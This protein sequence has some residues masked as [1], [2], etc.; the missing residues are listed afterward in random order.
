MRLLFIINTMGR[1]GAEVQ[2]RD[3]ALHFVR[4]GHTVAMVVLLPYEDFEAQLREGGVET[5]SLNM[6]RG[7]RSPRALIELLST[8]RRFRPDVIHSHLFGANILARGAFGYRRVLF[9]DRPVIVGTSHASREMRSGRYR[10]YRATNAFSDAFTCVSR[11]GL[12]EHERHRAAPLGAMRYTPNGIDVSAFGGL[13]SERAQARASLTVGSSF[14]WL[15]LSSFRDEDKDIG[16]MLRAFAGARQGDELLLLAGEGRLLEEKKALAQSL[17]LRDAVRFLGL[18]SDIR[19]LL[20]A[21]DGY[22]L[23]SATEAMPIALLEASAAQL[24]VVATDVGDVDQIVREGK[25]GFIVP[26]NDA[27]GLAGAMRRMRNLPGEQLREM[28]ALGRARVRESF[29]FAAVTRRWED[30]YAELRQGR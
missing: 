12:A 1:G 16:T 27:E 5:I 9:H 18:R 24:P 30:L 23:S 26:P 25:N 14:V 13:D 20:S 6:A 10:V 8:A 4:A 15:S 2:L 7:S 19:T 21:A 28:G 22:L 3:L 17:G 29:D 11:R